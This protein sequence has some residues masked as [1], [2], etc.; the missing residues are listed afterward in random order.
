[1]ADQ[2][3]QMLEQRQ[4]HGDETK[5]KSTKVNDRSG[6]GCRALSTRFTAQNEHSQQRQAGKKQELEET[7]RDRRGHTPRPVRR[8]IERIVVEHRSDACGGPSFVV[9]R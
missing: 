6:I 7:V 5:S 8:K 4:L 3:R 1:M 9:A 2:E